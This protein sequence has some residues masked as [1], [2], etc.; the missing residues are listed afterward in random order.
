MVDTETRAQLE[1][2][3]VALERLVDLGL[4]LLEPDVEPAPAAGPVPCGHPEAARIDFG[5][6]DGVPDWQCRTCGFRSVTE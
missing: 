3:A 4:V 2:I 6:T 1:R 5:I